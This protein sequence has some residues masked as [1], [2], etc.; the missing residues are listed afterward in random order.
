MPDDPNY[1]GIT[2]KERTVPPVHIHFSRE[3][4]EYLSNNA[5]VEGLWDGSSR[6]YKSPPGSRTAAGFST[7]S[8]LSVSHEAVSSTSPG[9]AD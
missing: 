5:H 8:T 3:T 9:D 7:P 1:P 4:S 6:R 2:V